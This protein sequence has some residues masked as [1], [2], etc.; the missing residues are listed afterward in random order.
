MTAAKTLRG[1]TSDSVGFIRNAVSAIRAMR[2]ATQMLGQRAGDFALE[3]APA[4]LEKTP[5]WS[6][7]P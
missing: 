5:R 1:S 4:S 6:V 7:F 2:S 3:L